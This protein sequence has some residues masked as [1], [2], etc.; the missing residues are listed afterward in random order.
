MA[1][2]PRTRERYDAVHTLLEAGHSQQETARILGLHRTTIARFAHAP[3]PDALLV[4]AAGRDSKLDP[5]KPYLNRRWNQGITTAAAL[6]AEL[7]AQGWTGHLHTVERYLRQFRAADGRTSK[8]RAPTPAPAAPPVPKTR[9]ITRWLMTRPDRLRP[10]EQAQLDAI[11]AACHH[12]ADLAGHIRG[13]AEMMT[14]R[15]GLLA[16]EDWLT[17]VEAAD[18]PQLHSFAAGIRRDQQAVTA[19]LALPYSSAAME[20]DV[21]ELGRPDAQRGRHP[22]GPAALLT[23]VEVDRRR[24]FGLRQRQGGADLGLRVGAQLGVD[25]QLLQVAL[26]I[27]ERPGHL[28]ADRGAAIGLA[29]RDDHAVMVDTGGEVGGGAGPLGNHQ[30]ERVLVVMHEP[31]RIR[32]ADLEKPGPG[33]RRRGAVIQACRHAPT[34]RG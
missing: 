25:A 33:D 5:F 2:V 28:E 3:G 29:R 15:Q 18:Q 14:R 6:H 13:F 30:V 1:V 4:K 24:G 11:T 10:G 20:R 23:L 19:G 21:A 8:G 9:Q 34:P 12:L 27:G 26:H 17:R 16:L 32:G 22:A 31:F 7:T